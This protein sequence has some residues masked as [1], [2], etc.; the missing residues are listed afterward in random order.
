MKHTVSIPKAFLSQSMSPQ[1]WTLCVW[2][3]WLTLTHACVAY[4]EEASR[5]YV[6]HPEPSGP[7]LTV[8]GPSQCGFH[9]SAAVLPVTWS[10]PGI[11]WNQGCM[12]TSEE[13]GLVSPRRTWRSGNFTSW[14]LQYNSSWGIL[15]NEGRDIQV[16]NKRSRWG[17]CSTWGETRYKTGHHCS[18]QSVLTMTFRTNLLFLW[19]N[20]Y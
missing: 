5:A 10:L 7:C 4:T 17:R 20:P 12:G 2:E 1:R 18:F 13:H 9:T 19:Q 6:F 3:E 14:S 16:C 8:T 11:W 15:T